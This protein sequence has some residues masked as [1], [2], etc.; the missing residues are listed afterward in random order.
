[1]AKLKETVLL[2]WPDKISEVDPDLQEYGI[3][4]MNYVSVTD[5]C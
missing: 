2:G 1:M 4:E 3:S 5:T